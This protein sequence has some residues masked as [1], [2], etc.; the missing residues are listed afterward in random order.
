LLAA[1][2]GECDRLRRETSL[3]GLEGERLRGETGD[4]AKK[5]E[6]LGAS[7]E[8]LRGE[9]RDVSA[10]LRERDAE[11]GRL[12]AQLKDT[13]HEA[14]RKVT[15][16]KATDMA[17]VHRLRDDLRR[18]MAAKD[19]AEARITDVSGAQQRRME[20]LEARAAA[21]AREAS[22]ARAAQQAGRQ[23][24]ATLAGRSKGWEAECGRM[25]QDLKQKEAQLIEERA[26]GESARETVSSGYHYATIYVLCN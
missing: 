16:G 3:L 13:L 9:H 21:A 15:E 6:G 25:R 17:D 5:G 7:L 20:E 12:R 22:E 11:N 24:A 19:D 10:R 18:A 8:A 1:A 26:G 2:E 4:L 23:E 14:E